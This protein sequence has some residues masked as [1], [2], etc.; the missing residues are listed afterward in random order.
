MRVAGLF[1]GIGGIELGLHRAGHE[2]TLLCEVWDPAVDVLQAQFPGVPVHGDIVT[3]RSFPDVD[4]VTAGFPCTDLSQAGRT[5]GID[6]GASGL[7]GHLFRLLDSRARP[8]WVLVENV[9]NLLV[10]GRGDGMRFITDQLEQFGY[11]WAYRVVDSRFTGVPQRRQRVILLASLSG[12]PRAVLHAD[13]AGAREDYREDAH[14]FYWTEGLRGL[15]WAQDAVPTLKGGSTIGIP[16]P[17]AVWV[18]EQ[19]LGR[20][21]V[22]PSVEDAEAMQGFPPGWT[23]PVTGARQVGTRWKLVGNA[24]TVGVAQ[25]VGER[26]ENPGTAVT[27]Y[28]PLSSGERW[29]IAA[30]GNRHGRWVAPDLSMFPLLRDYRHLLNAMDVD[31]ARP[32][33]HR[34][35]SGFYSRLQRSSLRVSDHFRADVAEHVAATAA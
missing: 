5:A 19:P 1:A 22:V 30:Y 23:S 2:T 16:S 7:V 6:G 15:G 31:R 20:R 12:D 26:L 28:R 25:W 14:G 27:N 35:S 11:T 13:E 29:P 33:S 3:L 10:L 17:P 32:V 9:R 21:L 24:V 34:G 8:E 18:P 4:L